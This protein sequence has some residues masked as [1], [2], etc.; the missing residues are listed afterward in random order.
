MAQVIFKEE[1][2]IRT[3]DGNYKIEYTTEEIGLGSNLI[4]E[5]Q[6]ADGSYEVVTA[7]ITRKDDRVFIGWS[8]PFDG[9]LI[10]EK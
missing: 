1:D 7:E 5:R 2:F 3:E 10:F 4:V 6:G 8:E 9:R